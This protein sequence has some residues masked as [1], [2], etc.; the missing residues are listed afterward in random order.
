MTSTRRI[1][2]LALGVAVVAVMAVIG[3]GLLLRDGG[4]GGSD[5]TPIEQLPVVAQIAD[6]VGV[7]PS[8]AASPAAIGREVGEISQL[9]S[10]PQEVAT[11]E[12]RFG[13]GPRDMAG[14]L[15]QDLGVLAVDVSPPASCGD[16]AHSASGADA[17][18]LLELVSTAAIARRPGDDP[19]ES[20]D[21]VLPTSLESTDRAEVIDMVLAGDVVG[22][23][24][25]ITDRLGHDAGRQI[26]VGLVTDLR[27]VLLADDD[28]DYLGDFQASY[29]FAGNVSSI[30]DDC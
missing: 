30:G 3:I 11:F 27:R 22:A 10:Q 20:L 17:R 9:L 5:T 18:F 24:D 4:D 26:V 6:Q 14:Q 21:D 8:V 19:R 12:A 1:R 29:N 16:R 2:W 7:D 15:G 23:A 25:R 28:A 13:T